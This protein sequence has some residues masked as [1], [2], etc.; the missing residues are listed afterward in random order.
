MKTALIS[1]LLLVLCLVGSAYGSEDLWVNE[2]NIK[3][4]EGKD[5]IMKFEELERASD[6]SVVRVK[7][8]SG[9]SV[10][11]S[12]FIVH[13]FYS[14]AK[15]RDAKYFINL[16]EWRD[17]SG[18]WMYKIGFSDS[19]D[20]DLPQKYGNDIKEGLDGDAFLSVSDYDLLWGGQ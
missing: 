15:Q 14:I 9:A 7:F 18:D 4:D 13:G 17:A 6:H 11:S 2:V 16:Q 5:L 19:R 12:M 8:T 20:I 3:S 10:P 1:T